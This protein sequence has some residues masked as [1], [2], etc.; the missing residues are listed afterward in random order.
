M[1]ANSDLYLTLYREARLRPVDEFQAN[2][3][4]LIQSRLRFESAIWGAGYFSDRSQSP[5]LVPIVTK[6]VE[7]DPAGIAHWREINRAD[8]IIPIVRAAPWRTFNFHAPT[9]FC[10]R[11][12]KAM[13]D[14]AQRFGR[15]SYLCTALA[16]ESS[17]LFEWCSFYRPDPEDQFS[18]T[19]RIECQ[20]LLQHLCEALQLNRLVHRTELVVPGRNL[21]GEGLDAIGTKDGH[22]LSVQDGFLRLCRK[23]WADFDGN[24][25]PPKASRQLTAAGAAGTYTGRRL[26]MQAKL[27]GD[28][29]WL[30]VKPSDEDGALSPRRTEVAA[31]FSQGQTHKSIARM[32]D[33]APSTVRNHIAAAYRQLGVSSRLELQARLG[34]ARRQE[35]P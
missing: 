23:E 6:T 19:E 7:I 3:L 17:A 25:L 13:L 4:Q 12:D 28:V 20:Q 8:K 14:Y 10:S 33:L 26:R 22:L 34:L 30:R 9:L 29:V 24:Q 2:A 27:V 5:A 15:Q 31:L 16:S 35:I 11:D 21:G 18:E 1:E 32:L